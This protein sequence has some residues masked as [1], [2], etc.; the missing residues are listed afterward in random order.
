MSKATGPSCGV[1]LFLWAC[2]FSRMMTAEQRRFL[3]VFGEDDAVREIHFGYFE[4]TGPGEP[5]GEENPQLSKVVSM[6]DSND[7]F[8]YFD[9]YNLPEDADLS[10]QNA[11]RAVLERLMRAAFEADAKSR[12][13][14]PGL[15]D[16]EGF[17]PT[18]HVKL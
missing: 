16:L 10:W 17:S 2:E 5:K 8:F 1:K 11:P 6:R 13:L 3:I 4:P 14:L 9:P 12:S 7:R 18:D 15:A